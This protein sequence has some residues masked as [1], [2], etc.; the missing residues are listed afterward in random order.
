[1]KKFIVFLTFFGLS[2][3]TFAEPLP[4]FDTP[5]A[6]VVDCAVDGADCI[7]PVGEAVTVW[8]GGN[9]HWFSRLNVS[10][11]IA[12]NSDVF[13]DPAPSEIK[14]CVYQAPAINNGFVLQAEDASFEGATVETDNFGAEGSYVDFQNPT[15]DT[16]T[17]ALNAESA[18]YAPLMLRYALGGGNPRVMTLK[19]NG[20]VITNSVT[21]VPTL[22]WNSW[23]IYAVNVDLTQ[24]P[25]TVSLEATGDSGPN[26][27]SLTIVG[28][29]DQVALSMRADRVANAAEEVAVFHEAQNGTSADIIDLQ[30]QTITITNN[31]QQD[32]LISSISVSGSSF[33]LIDASQANGAT[34]AA[35]E[36]LAVGVHFDQSQRSVF[37]GNLIVITDSVPS[38][39]QLPL[40]GLWN[41]GV[42]GGQEPTIADITNLF[43]WAN[44]AAGEIFDRAYINFSG[45]PTLIDG[46]PTVEINGET[47]QAFYFEAA[48]PSQ[49]T[50]IQ[51]I[52]AF[53][54]NGGRSVTEV[55]S[56]Q[57]DS[58]LGEVNEAGAYS[59]ETS[60][61][62][63]VHD[64]RQG[65]TVLQYEDGAEPQQAK[66]A[67]DFN[68]PFLF[69]LDG[70]TTDPARNEG[71]QAVR[72]L[73]L[74]DQASGQRLENTYLL[75]MDYSGPG[76][77]YDYQDNIYVVTNIKP[78][79]GENTVIPPTVSLNAP[80]ANEAGFVSGSIEAVANDADGSI[81]K[82]EFYFESNLLATDT[83][84]PYIY[85]WQDG[86][87]GTYPIYARAYDN[88]G[89]I[90][91]SAVVEIIVD[92]SQTNTLPTVVLNAPIASAGNLSGSIEAVA[93]DPDGSIDKVEFYYNGDNLLEA[94][95][96]APYVLQWDG[97]A[98][99]TYTVTARAY[100]NAGA[101]V[102]SNVVEVV[103]DSSVIGN[104]MPP[105]ITLNA[106]VASAGNVSGNIEAVASDAD[107]TIE[108]VEF[109]Y[110]GDH[111]LETITVAPYVVQW[112]GVQ[113]GSYAL[114]ARAYDNDGAVTTSNAVIVEVN[115]ALEQKS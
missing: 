26:V 1:M 28:S 11:S 108:K 46:E 91:E 43:G 10:G 39:H 21:F 47:Q 50:T 98:D 82:V 69:S 8:F 65:N 80:V 66:A 58:A 61:V 34:L 27:D 53:H 38:V 76:A 88:D 86:P 37:T 41:P 113:D 5:P 79:T 63:I 110:D 42:A 72:V 36:S 67:F 13:G 40:R 99:G 52:G 81:D 56:Y 54:I 44:T 114:T 31:G 83:T 78:F 92:D 23:A 29:N 2:A 93:S 25:N 90:T 20:E 49:P 59:D 4:T 115:S 24:G 45:V 95:T 104:N 85:E 106:P 112:D 48:D 111:L 73:E 101:Q 94:L 107:G 97:V 55:F 103:V 64:A 3:A 84:A 30:D 32:L 17:W 35:G 15:D 6:T 100:D 71:Y 33:S 75:T 18:G 14:S 105:T 22:D 60:L 102:T 16:L 7:V 9:D 109:Y 57:Y 70:R 62:R 87:N 77:N 89:A 19:V 96:A 51:Q 12:C 68:G 74:Y